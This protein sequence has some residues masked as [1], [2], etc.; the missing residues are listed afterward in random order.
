MIF[1]YPVYLLLIFPLVLWFWK[2][3][4]KPSAVLFSSLQSFKSLGIKWPKVW[5]LLL[6][7]LRFF[8]LLLM[9]IT[10]AQ[11][12]RVHQLNQR[13]VEGID[14]VLAMDLSYSMMA[15]DI[16]PNRLEKASQTVADFV[17]KRDTDRL[18]LVVFAG[19]ALTRSPL[20]FDRQILTERLQGLKAGDAGDGTAIGAAIATG[21]NRLKNSS[22]ASKII[23]LLT[24]GE[25]NAGYID[26]IN[27]AQLAQ[28]MGIK[29]YSIGIGKEGGAAIP[30]IHPRLGKQYLKTS[31]GRLI[32]T[33]LDESLLMQIAK[34]TGGR[35]FRAKDSA[36]LDAIYQDI[37][38]LERS[39]IQTQAIR[40]V[41]D[42]FPTFLGLIFAL[43][44]IEQVL[45]R[46]VGVSLP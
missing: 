35:Y 43:L 38:E 31:T 6:K 32:R 11:P 40:R 21:I 3:K 17:Q 22:A 2:Q 25:N 45:I 26:P 23:I 28:E 36:S 18:A 34:R 42:Y 24:D 46:L 41:Q 9:V 44:F 30:Y 19:D 33:R 37:N 5:R 16:R 27:A 7:L 14:I 20:T 1:K 15:E 39:K 10:L 13:S 4:S 8:I 12:Q 29:I